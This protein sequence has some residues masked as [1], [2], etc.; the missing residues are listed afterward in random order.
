MQTSVPR[1]GTRASK[2]EAEAAA[3]RVTRTTTPAKATPAK[4]TPA[5]ATPAKATPAKATTAKPT[6]AKPTTAKPTTAKPTTAKPTSPV[7]A[8]AVV[9]PEAHTS[10]QTAEITTLEGYAGKFVAAGVNAAKNLADVIVKLYALAPWDGRKL[11]NGHPMTIA[12]YYASLGIGGD[13]FALPTDARMI[14]V[15]A[16]ANTVDV[17][18]VADMT[19]ASLRSIQRDRIAAGL[20]NVNRSESQQ[21]AA[22]RATDSTPATPAR[23]DGPVTRMVPV[24]SMTSVREF[25]NELDDSDMLLELAE[26]ITERM[27]AL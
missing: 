13:N 24:L 12:R 19:G 10:A 27:S 16:M 11:T 22:A 25:I 18:T 15:K 5:K 26:L 3:A 2:A 20:A 1:T 6:T 9:T 14:V 17:Q 8:G 7:R 23:T 4:A 21:A